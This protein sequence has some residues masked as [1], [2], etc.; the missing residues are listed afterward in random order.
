MNVILLALTIALIAAFVAGSS[1]IIAQNG[2]RKV[3][4]M[5]PLGWKVKYWVDEE[6]YYGTVKSVTYRI[7]DGNRYTILVIDG[8]DGELSRNAL[9]VN[10]ISKNKNAR[11]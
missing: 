8:H 9:D 3:F 11:Q 2:K 7:M 6:E 10:P 5:D 4:M 1:M